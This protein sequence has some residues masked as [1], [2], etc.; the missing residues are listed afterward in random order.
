MKRYVTR[1]TL[2]VLVLFLLAASPLLYRYRLNDWPEV[3]GNHN[4]VRELMN[5]WVPQS[6][7]NLTLNG[8]GSN[9]GYF[10]N[11]GYLHQGGQWKI[12]PEPKS[13]DPSNYMDRY[14]FRANIDAALN[15][16]KTLKAFLNAAGTFESVNGPNSTSEKIIY[17]TLTL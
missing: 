7:Y 9:V 15:K 17:H 2:V 16:Q 14:N 10:V 6:R 8:K 11:V 12:D 3:Y 5:Q 13:Y 1:R 4:W